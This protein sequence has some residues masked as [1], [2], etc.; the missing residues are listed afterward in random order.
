MSHV[1][2]KN[3]VVEMP[4]Y[5]LSGRSMKMRMLNKLASGRIGAGGNGITVVRAL[6]DVSFEF[7]DGD[8]VGLIGS[9][10]SGKSTLLRVLAGI[11]EP[12]A[13]HLEVQGKAVA[14]LEMGLGMDDSMTGYQ[15]IKLRG[16]L[17]GMS[18]EEV[19][20]KTAEIAEFTSLGDYLHLPIRAYSSGM[21]IRLAFAIS[22]AVEAELLLLDEVIGVGDAA[23]LEKANARLKAFQDKANIVFIASHSAEVIIDM[24]NKVMWLEGGRLRFAGDVMEGL[25][26]YWAYLAE[27]KS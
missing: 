12:S 15:N 22:T 26:A 2:A 5:E 23:F 16:M 6:Q 13:G 8:R 24:C 18:P 9:N 7:G 20:S 25:Q 21:R 3:L 10:G 19:E 4:V 1:I 14:L 17:L 11:Y 27:P